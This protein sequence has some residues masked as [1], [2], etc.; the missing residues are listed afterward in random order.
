M[1]SAP[2]RRWTTPGIQV[3]RPVLPVTRQGLGS[4]GA[5]VSR[6]GLAAT[7]PVNYTPLAVR[8]AAGEIPISPVRA[9]AA[10]RPT[11]H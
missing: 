4:T 7:T 3:S 11:F 1:K 10:A 5:A 8:A 2:I 9:V 6:A